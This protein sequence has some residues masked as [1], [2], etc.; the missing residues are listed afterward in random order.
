MH[1][2]RRLP[3]LLPAALTSHQ[4][5]YCHAKPHAQMTIEARIVWVPP[6]PIR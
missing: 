5:F 6:L 4:V 1:P 3:A 2:V